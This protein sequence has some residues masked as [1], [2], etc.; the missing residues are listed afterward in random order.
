[1]TEGLRRQR[2]GRFVNLSFAESWARIASS[3]WSSR[4]LTVPYGTPRASAISGN[5]RS[6]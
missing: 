6:A 2:P 5:D 3:A 1:M 4:E